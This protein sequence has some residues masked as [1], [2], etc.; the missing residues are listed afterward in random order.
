MAK[1]LLK[2][3]NRGKYFWVLLSD[4]EGEVM[5][6]SGESYESKKEAKDSIEWTRA[7]AKNALLQDLSEPSN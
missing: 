7:N 1:Y 2:K 3:D 5:A 6:M 4:K